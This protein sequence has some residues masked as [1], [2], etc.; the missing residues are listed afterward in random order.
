MA[1][2][3]YLWLLQQQQKSNFTVVMAMTCRWSK[4]SSELSESNMAAMVTKF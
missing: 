1:A 3:Y 4:Q 2:I